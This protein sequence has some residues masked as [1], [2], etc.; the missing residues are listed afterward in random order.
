MLPAVVGADYAHRI[1]RTFVDVVAH[2]FGD[3]DALA[4]CVRDEWPMFATRSRAC[5]RAPAP[6][7]DRECCSTS[8]FTS[9]DTVTCRHQ[10]DACRWRPSMTSR[11][12]WT[13]CRR[14]ER[15][16]ADDSALA[17]NVSPADPD[18]LRRWHS[19]GLLQ[20]IR[21]RDR[22]IGLLAVAPGRIAERAGRPRV[23]DEVFLSL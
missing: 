9:P 6:S 5:G 1:V 16:S 14:Y 21:R 7:S 20:A 18:D 12:R 10:T 11:M 8:A 3:L 17:H 23:L 22:A 2:G 13:V 15:L 19:A 4:N